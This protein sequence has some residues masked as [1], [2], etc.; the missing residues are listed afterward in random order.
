MGIVQSMPATAPLRVK[1]IE[2]K[3]L[4]IKTSPITCG[5]PPGRDTKEQAQTPTSEIGSGTNR[6]VDNGVSC[7]PMNLQLLFFTTR[8]WCP[9][10][11]YLHLFF[12]YNTFYCGVTGNAA[13][14]QQAKCAGQPNRA[15]TDLNGRY[16]HCLIDIWK[17]HTN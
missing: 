2:C 15:R 3:K 7:D 12:I 6:S 10:F 8:K 17:T 16:R 11:F 9:L 13:Q 14:A 5:V 4:K 1:N